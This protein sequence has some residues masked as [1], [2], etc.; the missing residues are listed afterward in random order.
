MKIVATLLVVIVLFGISAGC[1]MANNEK[2][3]QQ[4]EQQIPQK[5]QEIQKTPEQIEEEAISTVLSSLSLEQKI[6][7]MFMVCYRQD[8]NGNNI[9]EMNEEMVSDLKKYQ[10]GGIILFGENIDTKEQTKT[11]IHQ[12]QSVSQIPLFMAV[13]EEGGRVSRL[14]ASGK[15]EAQNVP[16]AKEMGLQ[17]EAAV[18]N[19]NKT[20]AEELLELGF[21]MDFAPVADI[22]TNSENTV[23]GDR[24]YSSDPEQ[25]AKMV[26][27]AVKGLQENG[28]IATAKHFPGHG[29]T[30]TD[31]HKEQT[32]LPYD[33]QRLET[34]EWLPFESAIIQ[35]VDCI[36]VAHIKMPN[37]T[38]DNLPASLSKEALDI[39]REQLNFNGIIVTDALNMGAVSNEYSS[40]Q[41]AV[42]AINAGVDI[43]LMPQSIQEAVNG[44]IK[45]VNEGT[46][47]EERIDKS[48]KRILSLKYEKGMLQVN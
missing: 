21:N 33:K 42:M 13:D 17:G 4:Q 25:T 34:V 5:Q 1:T 20:I 9:L 2:M 29:D 18:Y 36:M 32:I 26:A 28:M 35:G 39:L 16:S 3:T 48:V 38:S 12:Y 7:Q 23:I 22:D 24:A 40:E 30:T 41:V 11:L 31:T 15:I 44:I 45:A 14:H 19:W 37:V 8:K 6:G 27:E 47:S 43:L 46:I 10:F